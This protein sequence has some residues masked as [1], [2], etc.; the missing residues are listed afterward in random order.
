MRDC[1]LMLTDVPSLLTKDTEG[2]FVFSVESKTRVSWLGLYLNLLESASSTLPFPTAPGGFE[3]CWEHVPSSALVNRNLSPRGLCVYSAV[4]NGESHTETPRA[5]Q[6]SH[7]PQ[8]LSHLQALQQRLHIWKSSAQAPA[9][10]SQT[11]THTILNLMLTE[12]G[13]ISNPAFF[14]FFL[15]MLVILICL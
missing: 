9:S 8:F 12:Y 13:S 2:C 7:L 10:P 3:D 6:S 1:N 15:S 14:S 11:Q 5:A 4:K